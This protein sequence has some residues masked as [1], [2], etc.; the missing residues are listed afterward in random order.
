MGS[1]ETE[2][3]WT[4][5]KDT[6]NPEVTTAIA[7]GYNMSDKHGSA[8][9]TSLSIGQ[10]RTTKEQKGNGIQVGADTDGQRTEKWQI[11]IVRK[12]HCD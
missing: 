6:D 2:H 11:S 4:T 12:S 1:N 9:R 3:R 10:D 7:D 8:H 5:F